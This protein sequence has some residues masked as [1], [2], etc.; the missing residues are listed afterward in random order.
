[1]I[2]RIQES[3]FEVNKEILGLKDLCPIVP[4]AI[5]NFVGY[6]R[7]ESNKNNITSMTIEYYPGMTEKMLTQISLNAMKKWPLLGTLIIH[8]YGK[9]MVGDQLVMAAAASLHRNASF[10]ATHFLMDYLKTNAP[11]WKSETINNEKNW[12]QANESDNIELEKWNQKN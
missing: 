1:M 12:V 9:L 4:G 11:F 5:T 7:N 10:E 6:V 2:I 3:D 8:R